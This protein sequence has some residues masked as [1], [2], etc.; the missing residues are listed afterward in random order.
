MTDSRH[1]FSN[2]SS[3]PVYWRKKKESKSHLPRPHPSHT[4]ATTTTEQ[5]PAA[6]EPT[7][8]YSLT[9]EML[10]TEH[11]GPKGWIQHN[12]CFELADDYD[13]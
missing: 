10:G 1:S 8:G 6:A 9:P 2:F 5:A 12:L 3:P 7:L 11:C 4:M 13:M